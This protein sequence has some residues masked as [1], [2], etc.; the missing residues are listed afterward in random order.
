V[1]AEPPIRACLTGPVWQVE[2][3]SGSLREVA[4]GCPS[5]LSLERLEQDA[6]TLQGRAVALP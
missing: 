6:Q 2:A 1:E 3:P 4:V 5:V